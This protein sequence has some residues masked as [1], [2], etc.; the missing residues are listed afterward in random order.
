[1]RSDVER[2]R[3]LNLAAEQDATDADAYSSEFTERV[4]G[5]LQEL[6][7]HIVRAGMVAIID[8][9]FLNGEH[10]SNFQALANE[11]D[12]PFAI[13][14]CSAPT[15]TLR[16]RIEKRKGKTNNV[17]DAD[18]AVMLQQLESR[19]PLTP[20]ERALTVFTEPDTPLPL[21]ALLQLLKMT[22]AG[23]P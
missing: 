23:T 11:L 10:R 21:Q 8:A 12:A 5:H 16:K 4:Y 17:S 9:T 13:I 6:A 15:E 14:D 3:L 20:E 7:R 18:V 1:L 22:P 19:A 2:K